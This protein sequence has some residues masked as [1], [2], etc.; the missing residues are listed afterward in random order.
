MDNHSPILGIDPGFTGGLAM[1]GDNELMTIVM[2]VV[3]RAQGGSELDLPELVRRIKFFKHI[4]KGGVCYLEQV[5]AMPGQGVTSMFRFG[6]GWGCIRGVLAAVEVPTIL[7]RPQKWQKVVGRDA[8]AATARFPGHDFKA[9]DRCRN[10][11]SGM[12][13]AALIAAYGRIEQGGSK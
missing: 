10:P 12:V 4:L 8:V 9:S 13:D 11:H 1:L 6:C 7:V 2:P 3:D 5:N